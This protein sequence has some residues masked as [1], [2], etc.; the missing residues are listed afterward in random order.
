MPNILIRAQSNLNEKALQQVLRSELS[1]AEHLK[2]IKTALLKVLNKKIFQEFADHPQHPYLNST[3]RY[4]ETIM[5]RNINR[6]N[7]EDTLDGVCTVFLNFLSAPFGEIHIDQRHYD[8]I[9]KREEAKLKRHNHDD[10]AIGPERFKS[11]RHVHGFSNHAYTFGYY[12]SQYHQ[13][14]QLTPKEVESIVKLFHYG[15]LRDGF[16]SFCEVEAAFMKIS[17]YYAYPELAMGIVVEENAYQVAQSNNRSSHRQANT[18]SYNSMFAPAQSK[19]K[20]LQNANNYIMISAASLI[21]AGVGIILLSS[22]LTSHLSMI[23]VMT[24][25]LLLAVCATSLVNGRYGLLERQEAL[26]MPSFT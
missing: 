5:N 4:S 9:T 12:L 6:L 10:P 17:E 13:K 7:Q 14:M 25:L 19:E 11:R 2:H 23:T 26:R 20:Q 3:Y 1:C 16:H 21:G 22:L 8:H 15:Y 18:V 24:F